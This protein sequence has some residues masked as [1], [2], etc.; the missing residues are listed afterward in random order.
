MRP[1][2][3]GAREGL[4]GDGAEVLQREP[5]VVERAVDGV[6]ARSALRDDPT[7][8]GVDADVAEGRAAASTRTSR[9]PSSTMA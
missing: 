6:D 1:G 2:R 5:G 9:R 8:G 7:R 3:D 4:L